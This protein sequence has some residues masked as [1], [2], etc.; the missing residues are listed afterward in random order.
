M[1]RKTT[2]PV[3]GK[4]VG[5]V[6][7]STTEQASEGHSLGAQ[8]RRIEAYCQARGW[9]LV[10]VYADEGM[11]AA[12]D[13]PAFDRMVA[14]VLADGVSHIVSLKL[15]RLGRRAKDLLD[16]YDSM[17]SKGVALVC[18][19]DSIDTSTPVGRLMR[20]VL[21]AIAEFERD[22]ISERTKI[23]MTEAV[24]QG[25]RMGRP[26]VL[27][28]DVVGRIVT[29]YRKGKGMS[30]SAIARQLNDD[31]VPTA[32]GGAKWHASTVR[33]VLVRVGALIPAGEGTER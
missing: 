1:P 4:A 18:I 2:K 28:E 20:T 8:R 22:T 19:E 6:R 33:S 10:K 17:E 21:A 14:D 25:V 29:E 23:G 27:D 9:D 16:L 31:G 7:V 13:R 12:K 24:R 5:Y 26:A 11:S 15:D 30:L 3:P 32:M